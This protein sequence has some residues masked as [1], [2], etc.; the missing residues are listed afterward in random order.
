M[1]KSRQK[2]RAA[3]AVPAKPK[4][5]AMAPDTRWTRLCAGFRCAPRRFGT[6]KPQIPTN[7][8][9]TPRGVATMKF[10]VAVLLV[11]TMFSLGAVTQGQSLP[12]RT[13]QAPAPKPK[14]DTI[15]ICQGVPIPEGYVVIAYLTSA[16]CPHGAYLLKKQS[17]YESSLAVNGSARQTSDETTAAKLPSAPSTKKSSPRDP[18]SSSQTQPTLG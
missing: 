5:N 15:K 18:K 8:N 17:D 11:P 14:G 1:P 9:T 13:T 7:T 12:R 6:R 16:A 3:P 2:P 10:L 4:Y